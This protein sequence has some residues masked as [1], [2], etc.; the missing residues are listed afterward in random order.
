MSEKTL[1][2]FYYEAKRLSENISS[3]DNNTYLEVLLTLILASLMKWDSDCARV[4]EAL[5]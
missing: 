3:H 5:R 1:E 2:K 4:E